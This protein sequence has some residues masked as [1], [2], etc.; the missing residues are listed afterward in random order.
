[1]IKKI[2]LSALAMLAFGCTTLPPAKQ[3]EPIAKKEDIT[4][5][6]FKKLYEWHKPN[7]FEFPEEFDPG[8]DV[9][10]HIISVSYGKGSK[11]V[12][13]E[14]PAFKKFSCSSCHTIEELAESTKSRLEKGIGSIESVYP[15]LCKPE[16]LIPEHYVITPYTTYKSTLRDS[17][18]ASAVKPS[19]DIYI[20][21]YAVIFE[22]HFLNDAITAHE[23]LHLGQEYYWIYCETAPC[24]LT[25]T[26]GTGKSWGSTSLI[27]HTDIIK[28]FID[29]PLGSMM[30]DYYN[31]TDNESYIGGTLTMRDMPPEL[32][33]RVHRL[34]NQMKPLFAE[35]EK[36]RAKNPM[37][38]DY[39]Y[40]DLAVETIIV[41]IMAAKN[42]KPLDNIHPSRIDEGISI[43]DGMQY[44]KAGVQLYAFSALVA[45]GGD[46]KTTA[47]R[48]L[49]E[50]HR[51]S[52]D[53]ALQVYFSYIKKR[54]VN[55]DGSINFGSMPHKDYLIDEKLYFMELDKKTLSLTKDKEKIIDDAIK[56]LEQKLSPGYSRQYYPSSI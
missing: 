52:K 54:F 5:S 4:I 32:E 34:I 13:I 18:F 39:L 43:L 3:H 51:F 44:S 50:K 37:E 7:V 46:F 49:A 47:L 35:A 48:E 21:P 24:F 23:Q 28:N 36:E 6:E 16:D 12:C 27:L 26:N 55:A 15:G 2:L 30:D 11:D 9:K 22:K 41:D 56:K 20:H 19:Q 31:D 17:A 1:M 45:F 8:Q 40:R 25:A 42:L 10:K 38:W 53:E 29:R 14:V 33:T